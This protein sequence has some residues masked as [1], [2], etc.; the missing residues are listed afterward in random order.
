MIWSATQQH[1]QFV[2]YHPLLGILGCPCSLCTF[3]V[4]LHQG[5]L[6]T[7]EEKQKKSIT[8]QLVSK[9]N[10]VLEVPDIINSIC[11]SI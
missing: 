6:Q 2:S 1:F 9:Y 3:S 8:L 10:L 11:S 7:S 5:N 4:L